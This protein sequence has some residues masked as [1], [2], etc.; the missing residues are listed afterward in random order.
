MFIHKPQ[1]A[2]Q[3][4]EPPDVERNQSSVTA[5]K[6]YGADSAGAVAYTNALHK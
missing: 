6:E 4:C 2:P 1:K 5:Q 3:G